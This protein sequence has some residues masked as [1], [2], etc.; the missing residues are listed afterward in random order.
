MFAASG[1]GIF[2]FFFFKIDIFM[3]YVKNWLFHVICLFKSV[4]LGGFL[5]SVSMW[6]LSLCHV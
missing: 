3:A 5:M 4:K 6:K 2:F 1:R